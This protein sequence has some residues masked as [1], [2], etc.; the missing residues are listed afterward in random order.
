MKQQDKSVFDEYKNYLEEKDIDIGKN[1]EEKKEKAL[2]F[3]SEEMVLE[4]FKNTDWSFAGDDTTYLSHDIHPYPAKFPPQLPA[5]I[6]KMLSSSG[7]K[8]WDPFGGSG[9]TALEALLNDRNC[10]STDINPIGSIIGKAKTTALCSKDE[11][12]LNK[13][14]ERLEYYINNAIVCPLS[15]FDC[16]R[17]LKLVRT[18]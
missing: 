3:E 16:S 7:E 4:E 8:V 13:L 5:Q 9:T 6:I 1:T 18:N 11:I 17:K 12:E 14:I 10:I 15:N 2:Q